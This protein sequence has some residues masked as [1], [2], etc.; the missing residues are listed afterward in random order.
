[1]TTTHRGA[2]AILLLALA[3]CSDPCT[4]AQ[5]DLAD[6]SMAVAVRGVSDSNRQAYQQAQADV[7]AQC[8]CSDAQ[9]KVALQGASDANV[10][11]YREACE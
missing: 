10:K 7:R 8:G 4:L 1:M 9:I 11:A 6:A 5:N 2:A 3:G